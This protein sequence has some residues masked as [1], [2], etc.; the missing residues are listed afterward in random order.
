[1]AAKRHN[2]DKSRAGERK[3]DNPC[4]GTGEHDRPGCR[5][6]RPARNPVPSAAHAAA[7]AAHAAPEKKLYAFNNL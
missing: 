5:F 7:H 2:S 4:P 1:M 6:W 3:K